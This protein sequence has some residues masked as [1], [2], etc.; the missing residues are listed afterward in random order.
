MRFPL[1]LLPLLF[2]SL[3]AAQDKPAEAPPAP[4]APPE[5]KNPG[6]FE[7]VVR[8]GDKDVAVRDAVARGLEY[9]ASAQIGAPKKP[10]DPWED[11]V[12]RGA[13][14]RGAYGPH[15]GVTALAC[16]AFMAEGNL[17]GRGKYGRNVEEGL[18]FILANCRRDGLV[19]APGSTHGPMYGHGFATLFLAEVYGMTGRKDIGDQLDAAVRLIVKTQGPDGG[20][21]YQPRPCEGDTSVTICQV[22]ALRAA[23]N[24]GVAVPAETID[25]AVTFVRNCRNPDGGFRYTLNST[26]SAFPRTAAAVVTLLAAGDERVRRDDPAVREGLEYLKRNAPGKAQDYGHLFYGHYYAAQAMYLA[27][28][29]HWREW[30]PAAAAD[31]LSKQADDGSF[32]SEA[33]P[34]YGTAMALIV[35]QLPNRYLPIMQR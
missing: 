32:P 33:G 21:R 4:P 3:A 25:R 18:R 35:L 17:P 2:G 7:S 13:F 15:V 1:F 11:N 30:F 12:N 26:G 24:A 19:C 27:G 6:D 28:G 34:D 5:A 23:R 16:L 31:L 29:D 9:L 8:V 14:G 20:W 22:T 10:G